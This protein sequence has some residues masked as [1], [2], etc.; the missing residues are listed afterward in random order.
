MIP[1][2]HD[3]T[4]E[5]VLVVG[6]GA[7]GARRARTFAAEARVVVVSP[8]FSAADYGGAERVERAVAPAEATGLVAEHDPAVVVCATDDETVN[9]A[10]ARAAR[11]HGALLNRADVSGEATAVAVPA[12]TSDGD[13][14]VALSTGGASPALARVLRER[15][16]D[17]I[18]GAGL[19]AE[20]TGRLRAFLADEE[21]D[22]ERR[23]EAV[24]AA[25]RDETVWAAARA[26]DD[27]A[28][29]R[30]V[31]RAASSALEAAGDGEESEVRSDG[32]ETT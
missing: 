21:S 12:T 11:E 13:V 5:T 25:V 18:G 4:G 31:G 22:E 20:A 19:V 28:V 3:L 2:A 7:V 17:Q 1:L 10:L 30:A 15:V 24:R 29:E 26:G 6:G 9:E 14:R 32:G 16:E 8:V 23:R 27:A